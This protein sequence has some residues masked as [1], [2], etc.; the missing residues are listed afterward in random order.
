MDPKLQSLSK[1]D[2]V[3]TG[4]KV[5]KPFYP[6]FLDTCTHHMDVM[7]QKNGSQAGYVNISLTYTCTARTGQGWFPTCPGLTVWAGGQQLRVQVPLACREPSAGVSLSRLPSPRSASAQDPSPAPTP[8]KCSLQGPSGC[9]MALRSQQ[10]AQQPGPGG[11][12]AHQ[13]AGYRNSR[14]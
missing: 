2:M 7:E 4:L 14:T 11:T 3:P 1:P 8:A 13:E 9:G 5:K 6:V 12:S 10:G